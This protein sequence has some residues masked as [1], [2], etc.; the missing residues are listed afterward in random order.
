MHKTPSLAYTS[1]YRL[2]A[3]A[4]AVIWPADF[5]PAALRRRR[6]QSLQPRKVLGLTGS[7]PNDRDG[8]GHQSDDA[9]VSQYREVLRRVG[10][11][12]GCSATDPVRPRGHRA[13]LEFIGLGFQSRQFVVV[14]RWARQ[15]RRQ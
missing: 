1:V 7:R 12:R 14:G 13:G 9:C 10:P 11:G 15:L 2:M 5:D 6:E 4:M 3:V 8:D